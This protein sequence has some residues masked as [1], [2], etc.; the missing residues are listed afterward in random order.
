[1]L[2]IEP[3]LA[4]QMRQKQLSSEAGPVRVTRSNPHIF[5]ATIPR[6]F[7]NRR[8]QSPCA[9]Q[10]PGRGHTFP[11]TFRLLAAIQISVEISDG[12]F[13]PVDRLSQDRVSKGDH[14]EIEMAMLPDAQPVQKMYR[15][16]RIVH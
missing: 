6:S 5:R 10:F 7:G 8:W 12:P 13:S 1:M 3:V 9:G 4:R 15:S 11:F 14:N 2:G 16:M